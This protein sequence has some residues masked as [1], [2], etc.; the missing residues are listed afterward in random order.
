MLRAM[1]RYVILFIGILWAGLLLIS[2]SNPTE[3]VAQPSAI[4][5]KAS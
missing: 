5:E 2:W 4:V 1:F 3:T